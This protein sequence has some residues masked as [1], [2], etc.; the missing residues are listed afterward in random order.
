MISNYFK[1]KSNTPKLD[2]IQTGPS[3]LKKIE[4]KYGWRVI[5]MRNNFSYRNF[6]RLEM[7]FELKFREFSIS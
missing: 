3:Q 1:F 4:I 7:D 2:S 6:L 5:E